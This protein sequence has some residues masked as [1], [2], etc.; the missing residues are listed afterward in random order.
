MILKVAGI[1]GR[2]IFILCLPVLLLSANI[3]RGFNSLWICQYGFQKNNVSQT[4]G[5]PS[6]ELEKVAKGMISY[7]NSGGKYVQITVTKDNAPF[8]LFTFE[9]QTH[10]KDVKQLVRLDH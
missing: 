10:L 1:A 4:S 9:E 5:L 8:E 2:W 7:F 3:A 6:A